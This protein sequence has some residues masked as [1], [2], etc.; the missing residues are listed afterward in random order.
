M[1]RTLIKG[2][3]FITIFLVALVV[4]GRVMN[5]AHNNMT[6]EMQAASLPVITMEK[7]G[8]EY[9]ELHGYR[10][11]MDTAFQRD[12]VTV[13]GENRET[14][15]IVDTYGRDVTGISIELRSTDGSRLIE[16]SA[17]TEYQVA[18]QRITGSLSLKDLIEEGEE[19]AL[20]I[21]LELDGEEQI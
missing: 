15:F 17:L 3:V 1:K 12:T 18:K 6:M 8:V 19:Y 10:E 20:V 13:L 2:A 14:D 21:I 7:S 11:A 16:N 9:N 4:I 5:K